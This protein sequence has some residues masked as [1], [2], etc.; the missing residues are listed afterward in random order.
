MGRAVDTTFE[1]RLAALVNSREPGVLQGG[2]KG[3]EREALRVTPGGRI[4]HT[5]HPEALGSALASE[6]ITTDFSEALIELVTPAFRHSWELLQYLCDLHQFV[7]R[8][9]GEEVLWV[10]SMPCPLAGDDDVPTARYGSSHVGMMKYVYREGLRHRYG[11]LMQ[12]ISGVHFNYSFAPR[13]WE[14][15]AAIT[16]QRGGNTQE[17]RSARYFDLVRNYRR[18]S[19]IVLYLF[20]ASPAVGRDFLDGHT[21]GLVMLDDR[22][23]AGPYATSLRMSDIG[24]RNR[25]QAGIS[26]SAN[27][28]EEYLRDLR[29]AVTTP[30][31]EYQKLG[32]KRDGRWIQLNTNRLQIENEYYSAIR[33]KRVARS[34]ESP[35]SALRRGGVEY[36]EMRALDCSATDPMGVNGNKVRFLE[37]FA[38]LCLLKSSPP[39]GSSEQEAIDENF[40]KVARRGREPGLNL[41]RDGRQLPLA[42]WAA[43][44]L[45][46]M[47]GL[48]ELLDEGDPAKPYSAALRTQQE[49]VADAA[50]T[51]SA[52][53]LSALE[54]G[55]EDFFTMTLRM[56]REHQEYFRSLPLPNEARLAEFEGEAR[57][58]HAR[59][60]AIEASQTGTFEDYLADWFARI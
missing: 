39:I 13:F 22:V 7:H 16:E 5:P 1:R 24:Y 9:L 11:A 51:P 4:A 57:E 35:S 29:H 50:R 8:H 44:I 32:I 49:K 20:G 47:T 54:S 38:A 3:V 18:L 37:A 48:C 58:S 52:R 17:F 41:R 26:V 36:I 23:A 6:H 30:H 45:D 55:G 46:C 28:L 19:W 2:L 25:N 53:L 59:Q 34:G 33:P 43:E 60:A 27:S 40:L 14:V 31:P 42:S 21:D 10:N 12:A 56:S 15:Y